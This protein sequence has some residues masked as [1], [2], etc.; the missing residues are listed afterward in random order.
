[1]VDFEATM[2][3]ALREVFPE[4]E[5][6]GCSFY[7]N[8]AIWRKIQE[9]GLAPSYMDDDRTNK[10]LRH[11]M[12]LPFILAEYIKPMFDSLKKEA[13][14]ERL[15]SVISYMEKTWINSYMWQSLSWTVFMN[16]MR[17]S[18]DCEGWYRCINH[19]AW[20]C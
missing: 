1:M 14:D 3:T 12:T 9:L 15:K 6:H 2:W 4:T 7:W 11:L 17:T 13:H 20:K 10:N 5:I 16:P 8:R 19:A 18:N